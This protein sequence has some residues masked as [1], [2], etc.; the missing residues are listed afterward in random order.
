MQ[1][2][3]AD[4]TGIAASTALKIRRADGY[5][6]DWDD[7]TFK[8]AGWT[9]LSAVMIEADAVNLPGIYSKTINVA[10]WDDGFYQAILTYDSISTITAFYLINGAESTPGIGTLSSGAITWSYTLTNSIAGLPIPNADVWVT[11]DLNGTNVIASGRTD[12]YGAVTFLLDAGTVY[13]WR[14][15]AGFNFV[16]PDMEVVS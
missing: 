2:T 3:W 16:N 13:V 7:L 5:L 12:N 10:S 15:K 14:R 8:D 11:T 4:I 9:T 6:L 1:I